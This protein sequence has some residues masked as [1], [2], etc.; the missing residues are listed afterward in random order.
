M[1]PSLRSITTA[2]VALGASLFAPWIIAAGQD[3]PPSIPVFAV[4]RTL[5]G[6]SALSID[7]KKHPDSDAVDAV[8]AAQQGSTRY[9]TTH[10]L[11][12]VEV[13]LGRDPV[14]EVYEFDVSKNPDLGIESIMVCFERRDDGTYAGSVR[15]SMKE[16]DAVDRRLSCTYR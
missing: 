2:A 10:Y 9:W 3:G 15:Q 4:C 1:T 14:C 11:S 12:G 5:E 7:I 8:V 13:D 6:P 16:S